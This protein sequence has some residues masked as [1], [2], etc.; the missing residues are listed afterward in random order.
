MNE[1]ILTGASPDGASKEAHAAPATRRLALS[2]MVVAFAVVVA[3]PAAAAGTTLK[4][5]LWGDMTGPMPT[6]MGMTM[7]KTK[8]AAR[9]SNPHMGITIYRNSIKAGKVTFEVKNNSEKTI[10]EMLVLPIKNTSTPLPYL[11]T[12]NRLDETKTHSL[13]EVSELDPGKSGTLT[14]NLK[15]GKYLL[16]CNAPG[17]Y[18]AGMWTMLT[19]T[20]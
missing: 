17:H 12:E 1:E 18:A 8:G 7:S 20:P 11:K 13:G 4:V 2:L 6:D 15:P 3:L 19:A 10:H 14:L 9:G 16:A 5:S